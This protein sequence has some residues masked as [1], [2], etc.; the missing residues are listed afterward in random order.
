MRRNH[1]IVMLLFL[2]AFLA[3]LFS[4]AIWKFC[5][6]SIDA[7][8]HMTLCQRDIEAQAAGAAVKGSKKSESKKSESKKSESKKSGSKKS[9]SK[10]SGSKN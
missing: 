1:V 3:I 4:W 8:Y 10:K 2:I 9:E 5:R 7:K 6:R